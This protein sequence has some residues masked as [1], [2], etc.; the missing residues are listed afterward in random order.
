MSEKN[1]GW[2]SLEHAPPN[3]DVSLWTRDDFGPYKLP[4]PCRK[5]PHG[6]IDA[7]KGLPVSF[8]PLGW[9]EWN[10]RPLKW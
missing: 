2:R 5:G 3:K 7:R 9:S 4:F 8:P 6:W 10:K 1:P